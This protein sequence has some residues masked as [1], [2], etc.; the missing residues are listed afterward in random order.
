MLKTTFA[1]SPKETSFTASPPSNTSFLKNM[2]IHHRI[3]S[4]TVLSVLSVLVLGG[5]YYY[6]AA[7]K[8]KALAA[9]QDNNQIVLT[10]KDLK[11]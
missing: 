6:G 10:I 8:N 1:P 2:K 11:T 7:M 3:A 5:T 9:M 4:L